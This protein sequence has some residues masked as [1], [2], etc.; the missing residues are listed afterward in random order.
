MTIAIKAYAN[1]DDVLIA[2]QRAIA[3]PALHLDRS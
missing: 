1:A 3:D 2:W